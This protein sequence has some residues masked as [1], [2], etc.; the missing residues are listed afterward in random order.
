M[1]IIFTNKLVAT[2]CNRAQLLASIGMI[3]SSC[4]RL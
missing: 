3:K 2:V 4:P 1:H